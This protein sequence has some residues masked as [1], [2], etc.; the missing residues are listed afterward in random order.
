MNKQYQ[1]PVFVIVR[2]DET[3]TVFYAASGDP[4]YGATLQSTDVSNTP[5]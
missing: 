5:W 4:K 2:Q 1:Q 3:N